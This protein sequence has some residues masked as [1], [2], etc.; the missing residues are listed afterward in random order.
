V[1]KFEAAIQQPKKAKKDKKPQSIQE[2]LLNNLSL[3]NAALTA[4]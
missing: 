4:P 1:L 3:V 2:I